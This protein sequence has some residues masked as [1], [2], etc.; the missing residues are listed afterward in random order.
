MFV[1]IAAVFLVATGSVLFSRS[2]D[3]SEPPPPS[4][5]RPRRDQAPPDEAPP[6]SI[7]QTP[8]EQRDLPVSEKSSGEQEESDLMRRE[9]EFKHTVLDRLQMS[10]GISVYGRKVEPHK[11]P[12]KVS[13]GKKTHVKMYTME[14]FL[15]DAEC[16]GLTGAHDRHTAENG[17]PIFCFDTVKTLHRHLSEHAELA[18]LVLTEADF[19]EGTYCVN[20]TISQV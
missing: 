17:P 8:V 7:V 4:P 20:D 18:K 6:E 3:V 1:L 10:S 14:H 13:P 5:D 12:L 11:V 19:T 2:R 9:R 16:Q 15:T